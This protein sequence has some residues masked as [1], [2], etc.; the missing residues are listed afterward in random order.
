M[1]DSL[2]SFD[3]YVPP[4]NIKELSKT[5]DSTPKSSNSSS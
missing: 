3:K 2:E 4:A 5:A 1:A